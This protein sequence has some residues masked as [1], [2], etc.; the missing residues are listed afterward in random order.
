MGHLEIEPTDHF[1]G[2]L[3]VP[4]R[5]RPEPRWPEPI[6]AVPLLLVAN[7]CVPLSLNAYR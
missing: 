4:L 2:I 5:V 1:E 3:P 7:K 6:I